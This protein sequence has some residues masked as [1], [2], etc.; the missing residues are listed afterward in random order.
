[1]KHTFTSSDGQPVIIEFRRINDNREFDRLSAG[2]WYDLNYFKIHCVVLC[3]LEMA[4]L[5]RTGCAFCSRKDTFR[6]NRARAISLG[7]ALKQAQLP[8]HERKLLWNQVLSLSEK[9][10]RNEP[11]KATS[12]GGGKI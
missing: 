7:E 12:M 10:W 5:T 2:T 8:K 4:G 9:E 11:K 6:W 1:M 3:T